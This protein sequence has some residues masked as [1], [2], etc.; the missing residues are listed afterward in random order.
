MQTLSFALSV[1]PKSIIKHIPFSS[2]FIIHYSWL[3][4]VFYAAVVWS[5]RVTRSPFRD[6]AKETMLP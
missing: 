1:N 6:E 3:P 2:F 5:H 4:L